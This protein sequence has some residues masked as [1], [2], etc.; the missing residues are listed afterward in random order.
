[1]IDTEKL[2]SILDKRDAEK[3]TLLC[4]SAS[5]LSGYRET[6]H[7]DVASEGEEYASAVPN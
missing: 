2:S 6:G 4:H 7:E 1:M 5:F 3:K